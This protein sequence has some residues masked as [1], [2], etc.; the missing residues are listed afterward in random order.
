MTLTISDAI[1]VAVIAGFSSLVTAIV[2]KRYDQ[3]REAN[4]IFFTRKLSAYTDFWSLIP[5]EFSVSK[6]L[7]LD[8][9]AI[10]GTSFMAMLLSS[11]STA[12][13]I[14]KY[15]SLALQYQQTLEDHVINDDLIHKLG[16]AHDKMLRAMHNEV[17]SYKK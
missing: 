3:R 11:E 8:Y 15:C 5:K 10:K 2:S 9:G 16:V 4:Q 13:L 6:G 14:A 7:D 17:L 12:D 1:L